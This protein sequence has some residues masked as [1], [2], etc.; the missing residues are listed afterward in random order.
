MIK[1]FNQIWLSLYN[2]CLRLSGETPVSVPFYHTVVLI[3]RDFK[4][5]DTFFFAEIQSI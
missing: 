1:S 5:G 3:L 4:N 2:E